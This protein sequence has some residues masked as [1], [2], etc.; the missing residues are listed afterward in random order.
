MPL[1]SSLRTKETRERK[2]FTMLAFSRQKMLKRQRFSVTKS[3]E[4]STLPETDNHNSIL[5]SISMIER[6]LKPKRLSENATNKLMNWMPQRKQVVEIHN[7]TW[8]LP[9]KFKN[10]W[11]ISK[12]TRAAM[13]MCSSRRSTPHF[14]TIL[15]A[16]LSLVLSTLLLSSETPNPPVTLISN[17]SS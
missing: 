4:S 10:H 6:F 3:R 1:K 17:F 15:Q 12:A 13:L 14:R 2:I 7:H 5:L 11:M 8:M 9:K 16:S